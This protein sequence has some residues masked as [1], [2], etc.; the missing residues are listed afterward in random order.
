MEPK[1]RIWWGVETEDVGN[2][3]NVFRQ[4]VHSIDHAKHLLDVINQFTEFLCEEEIADI[5]S[6][7]QT[8]IGGLEICMDGIWEEWADE[9]G[10]D[11]WYEEKI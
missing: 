7:F 5:S 9:N 4:E 8:F 1:Y 3:Y 10:N 2:L 11:I 6:E